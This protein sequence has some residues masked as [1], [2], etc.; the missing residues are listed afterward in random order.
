[1]SQKQ[2]RNRSPAGWNPVAAWYDG[3][4]GAEGGQ[5]HREVAIPTVL[6]LANMQPGQRILDVGA[7]QGVLAPHIAGAGADY[8]G[9]DV[10]ERLL[11]IA[12]KRHGHLGRF[13]LGDARK[14][15]SVS[16]LGA[17]EFDTAIFLLSIQDMHPLQPVLKSAGWA[18]KTG[19]RLVLFMTHPCFRIPRQSGWNW[20]E[21][22]KLRYRRIDHYLTPLSVPMKEY[23][24]AARG[25]TTSFHRPLE[26]YVN[27]LAAAGL[28]LDSMQEIPTHELRE[29][30]KADNRANR[31]IPLFLALR[32]RKVGL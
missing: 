17:G 28:L 7:G 29:G 14:L 11:S 26:Q 8:T 9:V 3:W 19:G 20:D 21:E 6:Q 15:S 5:H 30:S 32:A 25:V 24:G 16:G 1:M 12:R 2:K 18:L 4:M 13:L 10:S 22:R 31:E 23:P 27:G